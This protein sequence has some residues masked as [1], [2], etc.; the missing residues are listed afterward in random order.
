[1]SGGYSTG[2]TYLLPLVHLSEKQTPLHT[3]SPFFFSSCPS[4][5]ATPRALN[6]RDMLLA[7]MLY[8]DMVVEKCSTVLI[9]FT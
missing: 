5:L 2:A 7:L 8:R 4:W 6:H 3:R 9:A 1:V